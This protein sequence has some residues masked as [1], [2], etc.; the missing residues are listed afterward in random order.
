MDEKKKEQCKREVWEKWTAA[1]K[2]TKDREKRGKKK[3]EKKKEKS[4]T[5]KKRMQSKSVFSGGGGGWELDAPVH[6]C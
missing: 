3:D 2:E 1:S 5:R 4:T 6:P